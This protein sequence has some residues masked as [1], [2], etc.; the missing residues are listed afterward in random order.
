MHIFHL[1]NNFFPWLNLCPII[2]I[3][4]HFLWLNLWRAF[5]ALSASIFSPRIHPQLIKIWIL[6]SHF[7]SHEEEAIK[8]SVDFYDFAFYGFQIIFG[9]PNTALLVYPIGLNVDQGSS[10]VHSI[11]YIHSFPWW[12]HP[13]SQLDIGP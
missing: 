3:L 7:Q 6:T 12:T 8:S 4:S 5:S 10:S 11:L 9:I 2:M 1:K 13:V